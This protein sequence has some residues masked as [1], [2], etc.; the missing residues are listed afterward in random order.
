MPGVVRG[1][2]DAIVYEYLFSHD[3]AGC[4]SSSSSITTFYAAL[5]EEEKIGEVDWQRV[6]PPPN[7]RG[8]VI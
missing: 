8:G 2:V 5:D 7:D 6:K 3:A 4:P 1:S